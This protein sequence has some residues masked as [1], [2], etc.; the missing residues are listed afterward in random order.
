MRLWD[1]WSGNGL[2]LWRGEGR[3]GVRVWEEGRSGL[4]V[5]EGVD[6][7][8]GGGV[9][10][11]GKAGNELVGEEFAEGGGAGAFGHA[12]VGGQS[13]EGDVGDGR[14]D[15]GVGVEVEGEVDFGGDGGEL[16]DEHGHG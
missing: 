14:I 4:R 6:L 11:G 12:G 13:L 10:T 5:W 9:E 2:R 3:N 16:R 8:A 7:V 1:G 15:G